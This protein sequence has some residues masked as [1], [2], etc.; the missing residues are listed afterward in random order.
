MVLGAIEAAIDV[1]GLNAWDR[2][3]LAELHA[4]AGWHVGVAPL[5][6]P[7]AGAPHA[8]LDTARTPGGVYEL[9]QFGVGADTLALLAYRGGMRRIDDVDRSSDRE[10]LEIQRIG[11]KR[12]AAIRAA[13]RRYRVTRPGRCAG[14]DR[15]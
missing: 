3:G 8:D 9:G 7:I 1:E 11:P 2:A 6:V 10:L 14:P 4:T 5:V 12:L 13:I 15:A